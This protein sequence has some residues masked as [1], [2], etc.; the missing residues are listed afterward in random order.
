[1]VII[2]AITV[3][4][5]KTASRTWRQKQSKNA[6]KRSWGEFM[7]L[8]FASFISRQSLVYLKTGDALFFYFCGTPGNSQFLIDLLKNVLSS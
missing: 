5:G 4:L 6:A 7:I 2:V 3:A 1:M 8:Q